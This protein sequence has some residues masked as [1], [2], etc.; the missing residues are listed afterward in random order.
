MTANAVAAPPATR[1]YVT[2]LAGDGDYWKAAVDLAERLRRVGSAYPLVVAVLPD[3][4]EDSRR[5]L[6]SHGCVVR[7]IQ[8]VYPPENQTQL[9]MAY[10]YAINYS[11]LR[12]WEFV[13]YE[14]MVYLDAGIQVLE[15]VDEL[16]DLDKGHFYAVTDCFCDKTLSHTPEYK[17]GYCQQQFFPDD[18]VP[19]AWPAAAELSS[20]PAL[21]FN[22]GMFVHEP[23][24][25]TAKALLDS[26]HATPPTPFAEQD[27]LN[28][29]FREQFKPIPPVYNLA[30]AMLRWHPEKVQLEKVKVLRYLPD[31][32]AYTDREDFEMLVQRR[33]GICKDETMDFIKKGLPAMPVDAGEVGKKNLPRFRDWL[34]Q[35]KDVVF[36]RKNLPTM[37]SLAA[38]S[39]AAGVVNSAAT[40]V[41]CFSFFAVFIASMAAVTISLG[42]M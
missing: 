35:A 28:M 1:A 2:F 27:F 31:N 14:K 40:P 24:M 21:Y 17:V 3:V 22:A 18:K 10:Y 42:R 33:W 13:E 19:V 37:A 11:K 32:E 4:P 39:A 7:E 16:F 29:F 41:I 9:A 25:A 36:G 38:S 26:L 23:S 30:P 5:I 15:N 12:I 6:A 34:G 8:P 20:P